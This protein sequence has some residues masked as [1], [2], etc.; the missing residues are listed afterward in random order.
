MDSAPLIAVTGLTKNFGATCAL[1]D[2]SLELAA[3]EVHALIGENGAGKS[4]LLNVLSGVVQPDSGQIRLM[5]RPVSIASPKHAQNLGIATVFQELSLTATVSIAENIFAGRAPS[6]FG[7]VDWR[8]L[9]R[10]ANRLLAEVGIELDVLRP[11]GDAPVSVRQMVE[12][13]KAISLD[14]RILLLDE[15]TAALSPMEADRLFAVIRRLTAKNLGVIYVSHHLS[16]VL[17]IADRITVLRDGRVAALRKPGETGQ[18]RLVRDMVGRDLAG[19]SRRRTAQPGRPLLE[20]RGL[21]RDREFRDVNITI[22]AGEI[23]G[24]A[25]LAAPCAGCFSLP[26]ARFG[27]AESACAG[28]ASQ[29]PCAR[30]WPMCRRTERPTG[31]SRTSR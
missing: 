29:M 27:S 28:T 30:A 22:A 3:G 31:F 16:E 9:S 17:R 20:A 14:A 8:R 15:P 12:I 25:H 24:I 2:V 23:V 13:A 10:D 6:R 5:D 7:L 18:D 26:Q 21:S 1:D 4:T 19:W 11:L